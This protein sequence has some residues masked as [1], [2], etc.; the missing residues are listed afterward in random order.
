[1][2]F[3]TTPDIPGLPPNGGLRLCVSTLNDVTNGGRPNKPVGI[4]GGTLGLGEYG[5]VM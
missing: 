1:M 5:R 4:T 3:G 2:V